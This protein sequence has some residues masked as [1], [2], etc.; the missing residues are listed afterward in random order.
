MAEDW[1]LGSWSAVG[2]G[3]VSAV[4]IYA[5]II[6]LTRLAGLR[7][8][9]S[10]SAYDMA[11]TVAIGS[12]L[13]SAVASPSPQIVH[14]LITL[15]VLFAAQIVVARLRLSG[16]MAARLIDN[17]PL[18]LVEDGRM[19][20]ANMAAARVTADDLRGQLR[21]K[22]VARLDGLAAVVLE[23]TGGISVLEEPPSADMLQG[24]RRSA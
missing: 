6:A 22:G 2:W 11:M 15:A 19:L 16:K 13:A 9:A 4:V 12:T 5:A 18:L 8:L 10:M 7:S 17:E 14:T 21:Q 3:V 20:E 23:T 24:V 1:L